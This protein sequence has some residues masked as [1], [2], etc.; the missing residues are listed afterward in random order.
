M[1]FRGKRIR[2]EV[3]SFFRTIQKI[4]TFAKNGPKIATVVLP[5]SKRLIGIK[6]NY[7]CTIL[8]VVRG[9]RGRQPFVLAPVLH[10]G[11]EPQM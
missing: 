2:R 9:I 3:N 10:R 4:G 1:M 11:P 7:H 6:F 8:F 5:F